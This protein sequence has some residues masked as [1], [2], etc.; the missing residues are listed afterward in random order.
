MPQ[1]EVSVGYPSLTLDFPEGPEP[2]VERKNGHQHLACLLR[3]SKV[4]TIKPRAS[5]RARWAT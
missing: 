5:G 3:L 1:E 4:Q 2:Q